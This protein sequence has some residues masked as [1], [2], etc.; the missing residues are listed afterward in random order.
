MGP[1]VPG[2]IPWRDMVLW[3]EQHR[4]LDLDLLAACFTAMDR[5]FLDQWAE[6][7]RQ[8]QQREQW[9]NRGR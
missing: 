7:E 3:C 8:R 4:H 2:R 6:Q 9:K 1:P 5:V